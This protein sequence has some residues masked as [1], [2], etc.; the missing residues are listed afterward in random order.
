[1]ANEQTKKYLRQGKRRLQLKAQ[2]WKEE[3]DARADDDGVGCVLVAF[4]DPG[5]RARAGDPAVLREGSEF[6]STAD[7]IEKHKART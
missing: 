7:K 4:D 2:R 1:M 6:Q 3:K 5:G